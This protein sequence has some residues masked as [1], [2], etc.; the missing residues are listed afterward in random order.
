[1]PFSEHGD[2]TM[3][4]REFITLVG[5]AATVMM[6]PPFAVHGQPANRTRRI[7]VLLAYGEGD[8]RGGSS[9]QNL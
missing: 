8:P 3:R 4:R 5:A 6:L 7:G 1:M 9:R 2:G